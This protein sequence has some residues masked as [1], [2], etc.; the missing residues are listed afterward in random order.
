MKKVKLSLTEWFCLFG[1]V[2]KA[3][4]QHYEA[5]YVLNTE[6]QQAVF[7]VIDKKRYKGP[8]CRVDADYV[9][10]SYFNNYVDAGKN[11]NGDQLV[12]QEIIFKL[13]KTSEG[14]VKVHQI[15]N[16][17][18]KCN[19]RIEVEKGMK[20]ALIKRFGAAE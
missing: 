20:V 5:E 2:K 1:I 9:N 6:D 16:D 17:H 18:A 10:Y 7:E 13:S 15:V 4:F 12:E 14:K 8:K 3:R 11:I 19:A